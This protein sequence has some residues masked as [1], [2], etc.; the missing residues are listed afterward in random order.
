VTERDRNE[1]AIIRKKNNRNF[2]FRI[3]LNMKYDP[4][5]SGILFLCSSI[6]ELNNINSIIMIVSNDRVISI[7]YELRI[8][9][10]DGKVIESLKTDAPLTFIYGTGSLLPKFEQNLAGMGIGDKFSFSLVAEDAYG[11]INHDALVNVPL[12]AFEIDGKVDYDMV[13]AGNVIPMQDGKGNRLN[14]LVKEISSESVT[15]DF[16]H[17]LAGNDLFFTGEIIDIRESTEEER[18]HGHVHRTDGCGDCSGCGGQEGS[19]C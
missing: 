19:C 9:K 15:M 2:L 1:Y 16:N 3:N 7:I 12:R 8:D 13:K 18:L 14:G 4:R 17:P 5:Y 6:F 11:E 10:A